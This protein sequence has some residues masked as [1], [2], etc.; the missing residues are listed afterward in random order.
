MAALP[1]LATRMAL[2]PP[3]SRTFGRPGSAA[4]VRPRP[5]AVAIGRRTLVAAAVAIALLAVWAAGATWCLLAS[6]TLSAGLIARQ[7]AI[8]YAYEDRIGDLRAR[9]DR[10]NSLKLV[11]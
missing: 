9:L 10:V 8:Q 7:S 3:S 4:G 6:D 1:V 5:A 11:E 2:P